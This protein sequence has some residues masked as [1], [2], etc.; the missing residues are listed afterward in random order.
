[1]LRSRS[2]GRSRSRRT[3]ISPGFAGWDQAR[4]DRIVPVADFAHGLAV[5]G[6]GTAADL[7]G[8]QLP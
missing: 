4:S 3:A 2:P 5:N 6:R 1:M 8:Q 7:E